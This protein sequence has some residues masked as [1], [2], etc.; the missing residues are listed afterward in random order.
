MSVAGT[1]PGSILEEP[2]S[3]IATAPS[4]SLAVNDFKISAL[5]ALKA[6]CPDTYSANGGVGM[7]D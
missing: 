3:T 7:Y 4:V 6:L 5:A 1:A 2:A